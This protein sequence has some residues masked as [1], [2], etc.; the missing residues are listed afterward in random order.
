M[1]TT[2][3]LSACG[4]N[5][6]EH[7][8]QNEG[9]SAETNAA[10]LPEN[11]YMRLEG[12]IA[13]K[14]VVMHLHKAGNSYDGQY[15][16]DNIGMPINLTMDSIGKD[17]IYFSEYIMADNWDETPEV[18]NPRLIVAITQAAANGDW[19]SGDGKNRFA[20]ALKDNYPEGSYRFDM[21][22]YADS[23]KAFPDKPSSPMAHTS[24][25][26]VAPKGND[27]VSTQIRLLLGFSNGQLSLV[28]KDGIAALDKE[29]FSQYKADAA[30]L[31]KDGIED[32]GPSL[33]YDHSVNIAVRYNQNGLLVLETSMYDFAGGA[34]GNYGSTFTCLDVRNQKKLSL[35]DIITADSAALQPIVESHFRKQYHITEDSLSKVLFEDH[36]AANDNFYLTGKG[37]GFLYNPYEVASYAQGQINVFIPFRD[38]DK[39][40]TP[41]FRQRIAY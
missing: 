10:A 4:N 22:V 29:Y 27:W 17:S 1:A 39:Y 5:G 37:I 15:S 3:L 35:S 14:P 40:L 13:G 8:N 2:V 31:G 38:I 19:V 30:E 36:L 25:N 6:N 41:S 26:F 20:I 33:N 32:D 16:Y 11:C 24:Y 28:Y 9:F 34:H 21:M 18:Q 12:T 7:T 23:A